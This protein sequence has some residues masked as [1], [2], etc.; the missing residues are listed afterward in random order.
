MKIVRYPHPALRHPA[1]P[2]RSIDKN[3]N[4]QIG[5]M[6]EAMYL[7]KG[8]GLAAPQVHRSL[9]VMAIEAERDEHAE[10][11]G[12]S[13]YILSLNPNAGR[14]REEMLAK[15]L[16]ELR[17]EVPGVDIEAEQP[18]AHLISHMLSG[19]TAQIAI[20]VYGD[21]LDRLQKLEIGRAHV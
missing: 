4:I 18:L 6:K 3:L 19:V 17:E 1:K 7:A 14:S 9:Q 11:V 21:D 13:E 10:P 2:V 8:L 20:K 12:R 5:A 15:L 16:K